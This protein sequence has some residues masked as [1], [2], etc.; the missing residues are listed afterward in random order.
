MNWFWKYP[1][2]CRS[3]VAWPAAGVRVIP[4]ASAR[5]STK[6][7]DEHTTIGV[8]KREKRGEPDILHPVA[9]VFKNAFFL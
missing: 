4:Q 2:V 9:S 7:R 6:N 8:R 5:R 1:K 3:D